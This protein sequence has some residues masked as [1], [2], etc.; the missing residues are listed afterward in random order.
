M[1]GQGF[2]DEM[3]SKYN[4]RKWERKRAAILARDG[5]MCRESRRYGK[6]IPADTVHHIFP[7]EFFP[8]YMWEG[9][10][11]ISLSREQHNAMHE[12]QSHKLTAKGKELMERTAR[13]YNIEIPPGW[14]A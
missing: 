8:Q 7:V 5:Y 12:R 1:D 6:M 4:N 3:K 2:D 14:D 11:L 13:R 9:W 10:N